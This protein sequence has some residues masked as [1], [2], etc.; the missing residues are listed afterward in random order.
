METPCS[1]HSDVYSE[2]YTFLSEAEITEVLAVA[3]HTQKIPV[4]APTD[5]S[6]NIFNKIAQCYNLDIVPS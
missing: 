2:R 4:S 1:I 6:R 3:Y 5:K